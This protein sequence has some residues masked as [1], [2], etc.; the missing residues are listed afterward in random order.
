MS[1]R[2]VLIF[3]GFCI[4]LIGAPAGIW[5]LGHIVRG[6]VCCPWVEYF[7]AGL[8]AAPF[9]I[10]LSLIAVLGVTAYEELV[11]AIKERQ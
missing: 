11:R 6:E 1:L 9:G 5:V 2:S 10:S 7:T 3:L 8:Q 4:V